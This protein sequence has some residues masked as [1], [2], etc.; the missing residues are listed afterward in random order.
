L[1]Q[2]IYYFILT[3]H[4]LSLTEEKPNYKGF[5]LL[6]KLPAHPKKISTKQYFKKELQEWLVK[7]PFY[8]RK[9]SMPRAG[10]Q[11]PELSKLLL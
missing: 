11:T 8:S 7:K 10:H 3:T 6:T 2:N 4:N 5:K 9:N 1:S